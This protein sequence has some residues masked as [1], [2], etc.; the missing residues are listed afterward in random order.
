MGGI[1]DQVSGRGQDYT[2]FLMPRDVTEILEGRQK[3]ECRAAI[4]QK[5]SYSFLK[6]TPY[7]ADK[8]AFILACLERSKAGKG[9]IIQG[10]TEAAMTESLS[11]TINR[12]FGDRKTQIS[13]RE[14]SMY[15]NFEYWFNRDGGAP[16]TIIWGATVHTAK[17]GSVLG[18]SEDEPHLGALIHARFS[19]RAYAL[20][21]SSL[22]GSHALMGRGEADLPAAPEGSIEAITFQATDADVAFLSTAELKTFG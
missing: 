17:S 2:N 5:T 7:D 20:G 4:T 11:R 18:L 19:D 21:F 12:D 16:K 9:N 10:K 22:G 3:E 1:D 13:G 14:R 15:K 6:D 8:K